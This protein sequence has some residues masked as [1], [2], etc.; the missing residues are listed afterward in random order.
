MRLAIMP[1]K[2]FLNVFYFPLK[3]H[4]ALRLF[5][6]TVKYETMKVREIGY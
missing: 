5:P 6:S 2:I 4:D 3:S 1:V